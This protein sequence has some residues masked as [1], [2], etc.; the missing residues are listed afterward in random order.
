MILVHHALDFF[1]CNV[2]QEINLTLPHKFNCFKILFILVG[3]LMEQSEEKNKTEKNKINNRIK[4]INIRI[5]IN[6]RKRR[7]KKQE[8]M[9]K[10]E[11]GVKKSI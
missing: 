11:K 9:Y 6:E 1:P 5:K 7:Y 8:S 4:E 10:K 2:K 3:S